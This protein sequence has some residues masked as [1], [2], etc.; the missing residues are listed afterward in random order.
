MSRSITRKAITASCSIQRIFR[1]IKRRPASCARKSAREPPPKR[2]PLR[3]RRS[4]G[5]ATQVRGGRMRFE[6]LIGGVTAVA[7]I[8]AFGALLLGSGA[9]FAQEPSHLDP[10][11]VGKGFPSLFQFTLV[12]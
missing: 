8:V 2:D 12:D 3:R 6:R 1:S 5:G 11:R 9:A 10:L 4:L 7:V